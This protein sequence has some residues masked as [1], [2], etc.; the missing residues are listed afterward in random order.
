M[1]PNKDRGVPVR[2]QALAVVVALMLLVNFISG[3]WS[4]ASAFVAPTAGP[5]ADKI[6]EPAPDV[7]AEPA[8]KS[9]AKAKKGTAPK[10]HQTPKLSPA[11]QVNL[12]TASQGEL[13]K[14]PC[15]GPKRA[16]AIIKGRPY[17][18]PPDIMKVRGIKK[19][20]YQKLKDFITVK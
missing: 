19:G 17:K 10:K 12:N 3:A 5:E 11:Q 7:K 1:I 13:E 20:T 18:N 4:P 6:E 14:L 2:W 16:Q 9:K 8:P 15:V